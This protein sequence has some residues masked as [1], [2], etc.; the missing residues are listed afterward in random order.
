MKKVLLLTMATAVALSSFAEKKGVIAKKVSQQ[1]IAAKTTATGDTVILEHIVSAD[2]LAVYRAGTDSGYVTGTNA[3][4][5]KGFAERY[6][7]NDTLFSVIGIIARFTGNYSAST[8]KTVSFN[9]WSVGAKTLDSRFASGHVY[10]SGFPA[11]SLAS[12]NVP[13]TAL[14]IGVGAV[15]D[16]TKVFF[17]PTPTAATLNRFFVGYTINYD[18]TALAG[19]TVGVYGSLDG[20]R[21][22][23]Y[24]NVSGTDTIINN[25]NAT[26]FSDNTW[27]DNAFDNFQIGNHLF[28][29]PIV[30]LGG[31]NSVNG[32]TKNNFTLF[33]NYPNPATNQT[34]IKFAVAQATEVTISIS[35]I[36]GR[37]IKTI[38]QDC[39]AGTQTVSV[40]TEDLASGEYIYLVHTADGN[41]FA[42]KFSIVK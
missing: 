28:L 26:M 8:T 6:D 9:A 38:K 10:N 20:E 12:V 15:P 23:A 13:I 36:A 24:Y 31:P 32:I 14:G 2:T 5:D 1:H 21:H 41:G 40:N 22:I 27:H 34:N 30:K 42:S 18:P 33:G 37:T 3:F 4:G 19:D 29:F 25:V 39:A 17:F 16:T 7:A 35:D 11:T